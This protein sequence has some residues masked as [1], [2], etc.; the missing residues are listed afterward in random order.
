MELLN[1]LNT[2]SNFSELKPNKIRYE[3]GVQVALCVM[4]FVKF[5]NETVKILSVRFSYG[6]N[7]EQDKNL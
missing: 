7:P 1:E 3:N 6:K 2:F 4:K 5:N